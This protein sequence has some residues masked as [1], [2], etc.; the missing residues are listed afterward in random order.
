MSA[1]PLLQLEAD[2]V[3]QAFAGAFGEFSRRSAS[4]AGS[5][6]IDPDRVENDIAKLVLTLVEFLR[7]LL[8]MQ[9]VRRMEA[10][11]LSEEEEERLGTTLLRAKEQVLHMAAQFGLKERDLTLHLGPLGKLM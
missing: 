1:E 10:G 8:E 11:S 4:P 2:T 6:A 5:I 3:A 9:A 7:R